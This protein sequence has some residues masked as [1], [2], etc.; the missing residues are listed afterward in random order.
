[1]HGVL[2]HMLERIEHVVERIQTDVETTEY[3]EHLSAL[4]RLVAESHSTI[5]AGIPQHMTSG[6]LS[7]FLYERLNGN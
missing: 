7:H 4:S 3:K 2:A 5:L 6:M 1:M